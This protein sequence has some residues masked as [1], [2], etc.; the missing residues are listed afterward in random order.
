MLD[1]GDPSTRQAPEPP[2]APGQVESVVPDLQPVVETDL[3]EGGGPGGPPAKE[4]PPAKPPAEISLET[5]PDD[6]WLRWQIPR[7]S[8][9]R[10]PVPGK[11]VTV[12][13]VAVGVG[14]A[15]VVTAVALL[16]GGKS[17]A[18][19]AAPPTTAAATTAPAA[20]TAETTTAAAPASKPPTVSPISAVLTKRPPPPPA[21]KQENCGAASNPCLALPLKPLTVRYTT[22]TVHAS[23]PAGR[24][25]TYRWTNTNS[26]GVFRATGASAVWSFP[27]PGTC[28]KGTLPKG[29]VSVVV[30]DGKHACAATYPAGSAPGRGPTPACK[31][32]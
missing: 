30:S 4:P 14:V 6:S 1:P 12:W 26:C 19:A 32:G 5:P 11:P 21:P 13:G 9:V 18:H 3:S 23:D 7:W 29:T 20:P 27:E 10:L 28:P 22:Y 15:G 2:P 25:L 24:A 8:S 16:G 17:H 31:P